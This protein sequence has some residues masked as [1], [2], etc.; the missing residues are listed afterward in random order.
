MALSKFSLALL[1]RKSQ[2][3]KKKYLECLSQYILLFSINSE[4]NLHKVTYLTLVETG[5]LT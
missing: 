4:S 1:K 3:K 5:T 2:V